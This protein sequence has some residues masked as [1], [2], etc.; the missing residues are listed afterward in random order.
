MC[1]IF[2][3]TGSKEASKITYLGLH[4]LQHRGQEGAG[5]IS[6]DGKTAYVQ[7]R[8]G[9][10]GEVFNSQN[11]E[12]LKGGA[13][14]GHT[15][16]S[17]TG[18]DA[19]ANL[20]PMFMK[21]SK[22]WLA[23]VHNGNIVNSQS[24]VRSLEND[25]A[26][27]Q[28]TSDTEV[29]LHLFARA[30]EAE[31]EKALV[32]AVKLLQGAYSLLVMNKDKLIAIRDPLGFRPLVMGKL[33]DQYVFASETCA[34]DLIGAEYIR[35][36]EP[37]EMI[38]VP[39]DRPELMKSTFPLEKKSPRRCVFEYVYFARPDSL[40][41]GERVH[42]MRKTL[43]RQLAKEQPAPTA[44]VVIPVP[45]SGV[46]A[47]I[48]YAEASGVPF[49]MG[50]I[51]SHYIGRT[52]IEPEQEIRHL[53]V[54]LKLSPVKSCVEGKSVVVV[55]DSLVRGTTS[56]KLIGNLRE[57]GAREV[58][59]RISA[60]PTAHPCFYGIDTPTKKELMAS[61]HTVEEI[62]KYIGADTLGYL[63][64]PGLLNSAAKSAGDGFCHA[65]FS[66]NYPTPLE[67]PLAAKA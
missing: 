54:K 30:Q 65:C 19:V 11:L 29:I 46:P 50:I 17:T 56:K 5:I 31:I 6:T 26:I 59:V 22:G 45:D 64:L 48:G 23:L 52:F 40:L 9:L 39:H 61:N 55:D 44:E 18:S 21:G 16:Y 42:D 57:A 35:E 38:V 51:R 27:F 28:S 32:H 49:D 67:A 34:F 47:A 12:E 13:A 41:Y 53:G 15:R 63:S 60:P 7:R 10:V 66:G 25:G 37:G 2:G 8:Q 62:R 4:A 36:V 58:H 1:A 14:V 43:G 33:R 20:Q 24:L 3:I